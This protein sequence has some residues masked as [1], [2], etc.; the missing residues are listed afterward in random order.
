[1]TYTNRFDDEEHAQGFQIKEGKI[2]LC[3]SQGYKAA[4]L[5]DPINVKEMIRIQ[6]QRNPQVH[7][8]YSLPTIAIIDKEVA[9]KLFPNFTMNLSNLQISLMFIRS[10]GIE[11]F[12][13]LKILVFM[14]KLK[15]IQKDGTTE[16]LKRSLNQVLK[17]EIS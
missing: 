2:A 11:Q 16:I 9:K 13:T 7:S 14:L 4:L 12:N 5:K 6:V 10:D 3:T 1:M 8:T 17:E 15:N